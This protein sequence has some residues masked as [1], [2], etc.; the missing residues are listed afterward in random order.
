MRKDEEEG[1]SNHSRS[2][3]GTYALLLKIL[4]QQ[5]SIERKEEWKKGRKEGRKEGILN[6]A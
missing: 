6:S 2:Q 4:Q 3:Y 5:K 1:V